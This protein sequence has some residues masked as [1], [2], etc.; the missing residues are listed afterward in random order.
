MRTSLYESTNF[1]VID[2]PCFPNRYKVILKGNY[3][4][5]YSNAIYLYYPILELAMNYIIESE[6]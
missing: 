5:S 3:T 1:K 6:K 4:E 2:T